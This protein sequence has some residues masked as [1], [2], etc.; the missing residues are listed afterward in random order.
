MVIHVALPCVTA[1]Y[2]HQLMSPVRSE[3]VW[4][5]NAATLVVAWTCQICYHKGGMYHARTNCGHGALNSQYKV[6]AADM[7]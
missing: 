1:C 3:V 5:T 6:G 2:H 7:S 4:M